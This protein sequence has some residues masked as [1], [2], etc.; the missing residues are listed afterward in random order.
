MTKRLEKKKGVL[1]EKGKFKKSSIAGTVREPA[2]WRILIGRSV[3]KRLQ[4]INLRESGLGEGEGLLLRTLEGLGQGEAII[5]FIRSDL[6][7]GVRVAGGTENRKRRILSYKGSDGG[8]GEQRGSM[9]LRS[10]KNKGRQQIKGKKK[11]KG[12]KPSRGHDRGLKEKF[13]ES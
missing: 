1:V 11:S 3:S 2:W 9:G 7:S 6:I 10:R 8:S 5:W 12:G 13:R 4:E